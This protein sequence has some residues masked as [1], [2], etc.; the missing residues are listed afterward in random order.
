MAKTEK[1]EQKMYFS[2]LLLCVLWLDAI[3]RVESARKKANNTVVEKG[4]KLK[5]KNDCWG[6]LRLH[7]FRG[8]GREK[9]AGSRLTGLVGSFLPDSTLTAAFVP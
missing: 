7:S 5:R 6:L 9:K 3:G 4:R 1:E 2:P 8:K